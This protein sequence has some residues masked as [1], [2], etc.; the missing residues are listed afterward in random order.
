MDW[1]SGLTKTSKQNLNSALGSL[2]DLG[3][4]ALALQL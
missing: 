2:A 4:L 3:F 1:T